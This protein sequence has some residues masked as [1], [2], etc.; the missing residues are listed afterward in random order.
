M[1][2]RD[3]AYEQHT[4]KRKAQIKY[5]R[6][7]INNAIV[8]AAKD[9]YFSLH[10]F[11]CSATLTSHLGPQDFKTLADEYAKSGYDVSLSGYNNNVFT[12]SWKK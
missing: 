10:E 8:E 9:G 5:A 2:N 11:Q 7:A 1:I 4:K 6:A 12:I 3:E